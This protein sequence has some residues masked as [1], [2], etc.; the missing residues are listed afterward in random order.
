[1]SAEKQHNLQGESFMAFRGHSEDVKLGRWDPEMTLRDCS[2]KAR[3]DWGEPGC[4]G[5][6]VTK[7]R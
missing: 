4:I 3:V 2:E 7:T 5:V 1:M 6:F